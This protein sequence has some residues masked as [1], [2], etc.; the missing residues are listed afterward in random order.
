MN[1]RN[2]QCVERHDGVVQ[3]QD[4][5]RRENWLFLRDIESRISA[6]LAG[7][8]GFSDRDL[9]RDRKSCLPTRFPYI[10]SPNSHNSTS[11]FPPSLS[12]HP[13]PPKTQH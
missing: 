6:H 12:A 3:E 10:P 4:K 7:D 2:G 13:T 1:G 11:N 5:L 8:S 9:L